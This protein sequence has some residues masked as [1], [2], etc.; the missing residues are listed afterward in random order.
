VQHF[1]FLPVEVQDELFQRMPVSFTPSSDKK[2]LSHAL[3][4]TL[5]IPGTRP[6]LAADVRKM[7]GFGA[8]SVVLCLEDAVPDAK[9]LEAEANVVKALAVISDLD[10]TISP[11]L[12]FLR[13]RNPDHL[14]KIAGLAGTS[15]KALT[16]FVF[17][18]FENI[19]NNAED[20]VE[21]LK[22][23]NIMLKE[24]TN[25]DRNLYF[26]PVIESPNVAYR[27]TRKGVLS[28]IKTIVDQNPELVLGVR[29]GATDISSVYGIRR[30]RDFTVYD[31]HVVSSVIA[32]IVNIFGRNNE[33]YTISGPVWEH[34]NSKERLFKPQ[35]RESLFSESALRKKL[36]NDSFDSFIREIELDKA[37]GL[38]GK[39]II[40]PSHIAL[41]HSLSV[42]TDEEYSDALDITSSEKST[43]GA[44]AST[45]R[46]KMNEVKPHLSWAH[47]VLLR[48]DAFGVAQKD[49]DFVNFLKA[50]DDLWA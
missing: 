30:P 45:Y 20:F 50:I 36:L 19:S 48:A 32:D 7:A 46:N 3:G 42:V 27:E 9:L 39:T 22:N 40:H 26:M 10:D 16:G 24:K 18:K 29:I 28:G 41:I 49:V 38:T 14:V 21:I 31:V 33:D 37:N 47:K 12:V 11:P 43:G 17:P 15:L 5:Y 2:L 4:G 8:R 1:S 35:L 23:I 25:I 44:H 34:F 13:V 6:D